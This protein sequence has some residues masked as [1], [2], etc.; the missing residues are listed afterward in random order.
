[1]KLTLVNAL[2]HPYQVGGA[3]KSV[4]LL[5]EALA[6]QGHTVSVI[7][8]HP[9]KDV[10]RR[11]HN[12]VEAIHIPL[13]NSYWPYDNKARRGFLS[14]TGWH[15]R[16]IWN[17]AT[18]A[19]AGRILDD[20]RPDVVHVNVSTGFSAALLPEILSRKI[21]LVQTLRDYTYMC[22][23]SGLYR[24]GE[25]CQSQCF[26][27]RLFTSQ[28][29]RLS[30]RI[31]AVVSNSQY[32]LDAHLK[33][34]FFPGVPA[35]VIFNIANVDGLAIPRVS[36]PANP[37][38]LTFGFLGRIVE[39]KGIDVV[40]EATKR[41]KSENWCL[42]I[43]G[44]GPED[45]VADLKRRHHDPRIE[46]LGFI[47]PRRFFEQTDVVLVSSVYPEP[48]PRSLIESYAAGRT[49]IASRAGGNL[50]V[51]E[52]GKTYSTYDAKS[53]DQLAQ[54][55]DDAVMASTKWQQGGFASPEQAQLFSEATVTSRYIG[56]YERSRL[57][58]QGDT[59]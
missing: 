1:M 4:Q 41:M 33:C 6:R 39:E 10:Q 14:R 31:S 53:A 28:Y 8:L 57:S 23:R 11:T 27:C 18:A 40:L 3:E 42:K 30:H 21:P 43:G 2:Y 55:M 36:D 38:R 35:Q 52:L 13:S 9:E 19:S 15:L 34:G 56:V 51:A 7:A 47:E 58:P 5:A 25:T 45:Y 50:E 20:L 22:E 24:R 32:V 46:W 59:H 26:D 16:N 48:L 29:K 37:D 44:S 12:G 49:V 54:L 17:S